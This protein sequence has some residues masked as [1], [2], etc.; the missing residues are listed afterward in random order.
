VS[1]ARAARLRFL[2]RFASSLGV[3]A[4]VRL[5]TLYGFPGLDIPEAV[6]F[7]W[8]A[9]LPV[10]FF[11]EAL[12]RLLWVEDPW[13]FIARSPARY[14]LLTMIVLE[15][16]GV[17]TWGS[18]REPG[19]SLLLGEVYLV[20]F[21]F[22]FA[23]SWAKGA[24]LANRWLA[25]RRIPVL[26]LPSVLFAVVIVLGAAVLA[27][28]GLHQSSPSLLDS[29]FTAASALCVTG[30]A[31]YDVASTLNP[32][33]QFVLA[34]LIQV[35]GLGILTVLGW[36]ALWQRGDLTF[37]EHTQFSELVG[38]MNRAETKKLLALVLRVTLL[39]EGLGTLGFWLLWR[40]R[41]E[42]ALPLG[43]FHAISAFCNAGFA[44]FPDSFAGFRQDPATLVVLMAL[45]VAGGAGFPVLASLGRVVRSRVLP[46]DENERLSHTARIVFATSGIL[47]LAGAVAFS[48]DG[49]LQGR[50]RGALE[51][52]FQSVT[53]RTAGFQVE[54][55]LGFGVV[56]LVATVVLMAIGA[57]PQ[58]TG[59]GIKTVVFARLFR[60]MS[61][62]RRGEPAHY[63]LESFR[64]ALQL[65]AVYAVAGFLAAGALRWTDG[66]DKRDAIFEAFSGL[67]TVG[68]TRDVTPRLSDPGKSLV[69]VLMFAGRV[70][71]PTLVLAWTRSR[72]HEVEAVP[73]T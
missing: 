45:I 52:V 42:H 70:L 47:V 1:G 10:G 5:V 21:L 44:L 68:L 2:D 61:R 73:W 58:S 38:G 60:R 48:I 22:G 15:V 62:P 56:G 34:V 20:I 14:I 67:G 13:R 11:L 36:M 23:G 35:G 29:L 25:N 43:A 51:A 55:Q 41:I 53:A 59:G 6:L 32:V 8:S 63:R 7:A 28:P 4:L 31:V 26:V 40:D 72:R 33:G 64:I 3:L 24:L 16:S 65:C 49:W 27:L 71:V 50:P 17:A 66:L 39:S 9:I 18:S 30:L 54:S 37:G 69:I 19:T 57:S 46:W 12:Y